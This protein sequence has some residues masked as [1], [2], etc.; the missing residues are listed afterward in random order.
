M[1]QNQSEDGTPTGNAPV[2]NN[3]SSG[4]GSSSSNVES[5]AK[6]NS[7]DLVEA[8]TAAMPPSM[9]SQRSKTAD[10]ILAEMNR[11]PLF[12]TTLDETD[13]EGGENVM[14]EAIKALAYEGSKAEV[15]A[16]FREQG[17]EAA[18][19]K[20]WKDAREFYTKAIA[21]V[22]GKVKLSEAPNDDDFAGAAGADAVPTTSTRILDVTDVEEDQVTPVDEE[23][24][25]KKEREIEEAC[26][27]NRALCNLEMSITSPNPSSPTTTTTTSITITTTD[28]KHPQVFPPHS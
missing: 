24:E 13:G 26:L 3:S 23:A 5:T 25:A 14:L 19:G 18:R 6:H 12:M 16:N 20:L 9:S 10:E 15:A 11:I 22:Q 8:L 17:N 2:S 27:A 28:T 21:S 7:D 1:A 4:G